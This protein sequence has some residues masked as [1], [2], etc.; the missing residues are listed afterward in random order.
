MDS[1]GTE[2][3]SAPCNCQND[4][5]RRECNLYLYTNSQI[6]SFSDVQ[7]IPTICWVKWICLKW[8]TG[9]EP[10]MALGVGPVLKHLM[11]QCPPDLCSLG[12]SETGK[13]VRRTTGKQE[14]M[15]PHRTNGYLCSLV[16]RLCLRWTF[17]TEYKLSRIFQWPVQLAVQEILA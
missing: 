15:K 2:T 17:E 7:E 5:W 9:R 4:I 14:D 3:T 6:I 16:S 11:D 1:R 10:V 8:V 12:Q 13:P